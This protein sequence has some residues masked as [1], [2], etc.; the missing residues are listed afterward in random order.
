M[1]R[2]FISF[3]FFAAALTVFILSC[4]K[5]GYSGND[6]DNV[7]PQS[8]SDT[9]YGVTN[10]LISDTPYGHKSQVSL[11]QKDEPIEII[12]AAM[13]DTPYGR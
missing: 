6:V 2:S 10:G 12:Q 1:K 7:I 5:K 4:S 13:A 9:P 11:L 3:S 8:K